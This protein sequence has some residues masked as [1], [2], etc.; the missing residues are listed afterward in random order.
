MKLSE[1]F[2]VLQSVAPVALSNEFC[3]KC[4]MYDNS[5]YIIDFG[6]EVTGA[7]FSLDLSLGAVEQAKRLGY[8]LIVTHHPAI[9]G[10]VKNFNVRTSPQA[11]CLAECLKCG[12]SVISMH[13]NFDAAPKGIDY[14]LMQ[15]LGGNDGKL[16]VE[17]SAGGYGRVYDVPKTNFFDYFDSVKKTFASERALRFGKDGKISR[18]ASFCG[19]GCDENSIEFAANNNADVFV[20]SDIKEHQIAELLGRGIK[21][22]QLTHYSS[23]AYGFNRIYKKISTDLPVSSFYFDEEMA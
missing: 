16:M 18:V 13:L 15:G 5:G 19:S 1:V 8:N 22:I 14:Y 2:D 23:E 21:V 9:F 10:G 17:L 7:L 3:A 20:S 6:G 12:I 11:K 4:D